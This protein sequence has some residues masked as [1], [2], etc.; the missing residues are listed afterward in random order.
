VFH[1]DNAN[2]WTSYPSVTVYAPVLTYQ[3][4][5]VV[6]DDN[7]NGILDPGETADLVVTL[8]NEGGAVAENVN[9]SLMT[10]SADITINDGDASFGFID[11]GMTANNASDPYNVTA[12]SSI[13]TGTVIDFELEVVSGV[14]VDTL[15]FNLVVGKKHYYIW[16][17][18]PTPTPGQNVHTIL[19]NLGYTGDY[20]ST[21]AS[22][23]YMYQS[24]FVSVGVFSSNYVIE[25]GSP[26]ATALVNFLQNQ[27]GRMYLEGGDVWYY[28]PLYGGYD[29]GPLFGIDGLSDGSGDLYTVTG[30]SG[31]FT[32]GMSFSYGGDNS[33]IDHLKSTGTGY[34]IF[35]NASNS[36]SIG[37]ANNAGT[38]RTVGT[39]FELG[40]LDDGTPPSTRA[41][42]LDS[43]MDFF[44]IGTNVGID[45][46]EEVS[47]VPLQT[48]LGILYP[49]PFRDRIEI[50][51][52][53]GPG[54]KG[55][56]LKV[57]NATGRL[58]KSFNQLP[59]NR[60]LVNHV[61][62][63]GTDDN[64]RRVPAGVYFVSFTT[65]HHQQVEKAILL[66]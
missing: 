24:V 33:Y 16:N 53:I 41:A 29:F 15:Q 35:K 50:R 38:Y 47:S 20:G 31:T 66:K 57:Y 55:I 40:L 46:G 22:D 4:V 61:I 62:W 30:L 51:Y 23:L 49:N 42:I 37:V 25:D 13:P 65:D 64:G 54:A 59:K 21:L 2:T 60:S 6:D 19:T 36:D 1:D 9:S 7:G 34:V 5:S 18:D 11:P 39:S 58:V 14:Y 44:D 63:D 45:E 10:L 52:S 32:Q 3:E 48:A 27:G 43:I 17:P 28:D 12:D 26:E 56:A 8:E